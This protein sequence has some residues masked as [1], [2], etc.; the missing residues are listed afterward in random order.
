MVRLGWKA[1]VEQY[2]PTQILEYAVAAEEAGFDLIRLPEPLQP[3]QLGVAAQVA[4][5]LP[6]RVE[7]DEQPAAVRPAAAGPYR[8]SG[9]RRDARARCPPP[10]SPRHDPADLRTILSTISGL[11][12]NEIS[13]GGC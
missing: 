8:V 11:G 5:G 6:V 4:H 3:D 7:R 13:K 1:G 12:V 9:L 10:W 2:P